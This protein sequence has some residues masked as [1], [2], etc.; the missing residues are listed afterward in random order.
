[1]LGRDDTQQPEAILCNTSLLYCIWMNKLLINLFR[2]IATDSNSIFLQWMGISC[3]LVSLYFKVTHMDW[4]E[5]YLVN[6]ASQIIN[7]IFLFVSMAIGKGS[8]VPYFQIDPP[9]LNSE[10]MSKL[11]LCIEWPL[12]E[13]M[14]YPWT[15]DITFVSLNENKQRRTHVDHAAH[16]IPSRY[17]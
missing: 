15:H 9:D 7:V 4:L 11:V 2:N 8:I 6:S 10:V 16:Y 13:Y 12:S 14:I 5:N 1:M 17:I 3:G